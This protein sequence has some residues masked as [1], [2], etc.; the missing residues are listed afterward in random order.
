[1]AMRYGWNS[2]F[3]VFGLIGIAYSV[4]IA[5]FLRDPKPEVA[6][7]APSTETI[8]KINF[9]P[10]SPALQPFLV[11]LMVLYWGLLGLAGW[12]LVGWMP[13]YL[14]EHFHL[15]QDE[16]GFYAT[17]SLHHPLSIGL[18]LGGF[19]ADYWSRT[20][21][22]AASLF[23]S[24][25]C[26]AR[27]WCAARFANRCLVVALF[28]LVIYGIMRS[29]TD[30]NTMPVL[31]M[32]SDPRLPCDGLRLVKHVQLHH[33]RPYDLRRRRPSRRPGQRQQS[34]PFCRPGSR[35]LRR[36]CWSW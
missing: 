11:F 36:S 32:V 3:T 15:P 10:P 7:V 35:P 18:L 1:M 31:C 4:L 9:S 25:A 26:V 17:L 19:L 8:G 16:A 29:F 12:A 13:T 2:A 33:R 30:A 34:V 6:A 27:P 23:P 22:A 5:F 24:S 21:N 14:Y 28:G 20:M